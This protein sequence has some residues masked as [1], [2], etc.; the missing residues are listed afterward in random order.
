MKKSSVIVNNLFL[1]AGILCL[2]FYLTEGITVRF[3][4]SMLWVWL[5]LGLAV[6]A[7]G[8]FGGGPGSRGSAPPCPAGP[9]GRS[10]FW[11]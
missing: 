3:G 1:I 9:S 4:Q 8:I 10:A 6:S 11:R 5:V 2:L 7:A